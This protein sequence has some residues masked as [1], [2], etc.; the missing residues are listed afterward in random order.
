MFDVPFVLL[1]IR[2]GGAM[3]ADKK[4]AYAAFRARAEF[5]IGAFRRDALP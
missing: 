3:V 1:V 5:I 4:G 2:E